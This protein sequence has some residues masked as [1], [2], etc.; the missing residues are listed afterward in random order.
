M[1]VVS[2]DL[3]V[4]KLGAFFVDFFITHFVC[5]GHVFPPLKLLALN[6]EAFIKAILS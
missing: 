1:V 2:L 5:V 3:L 4:T 6:F